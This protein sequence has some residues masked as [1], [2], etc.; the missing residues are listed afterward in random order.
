MTPLSLV[1]IA[2][3]KF[4]PGLGMIGRLSPPTEM[5]LLSTLHIFMPREV[6]HTKLPL[7]VRPSKIFYPQLLL[8]Y[9]LD[10][11]ETWLD[12]SLGWEYVH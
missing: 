12:C 2:S 7:S 6:G 9:P 3:R 10:C 11:Y 8:N 1:A 4:R 5:C